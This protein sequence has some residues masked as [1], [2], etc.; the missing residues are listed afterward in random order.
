MYGSAPTPMR[1]FAAASDVAWL[2]VEHLQQ[3]AAVEGG[4]T[5]AGYRILVARAMF[6]LKCACPAHISVNSWALSFSNSMPMSAAPLNAIRSQDMPV[7]PR[8]S[9]TGTFAARLPTKKRSRSGIRRRMRPV[10]RGCGV[11]HSRAS[12]SSPCPTMR[13]CFSSWDVVMSIA[14]VPD[15]E[16]DG[17]VCRLRRRYERLHIRFVSR[18]HASGSRRVRSKSGGE[19]VPNSRG[20]RV[21]AGSGSGAPWSAG[22][23]G[24]SGTVQAW[25]ML[26]M[27][28]T[29]SKPPECGWPET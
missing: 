11:C 13:G 4:V 25:E 3:T 23:T 1:I 9:R 24:K 10:R 15:L 20:K 6:S 18:L 19:R 8:I 17:A 12:A 16:D 29:M 2:I 14:Y 26:G 7:L 21:R 22:L 5:V 28:T 27:V